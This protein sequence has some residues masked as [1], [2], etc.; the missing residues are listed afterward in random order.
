MN[1]PAAFRVALLDDDESSRESLDALLRSA[2]FDVRA[3]AVAR[4]FLDWDAKESIDLAILDYAM[5]PMNGGEVQEVLNTRGRSY[6]VIFLTA[7]AS[8]A[9]RTRLVA[10]GAVG[11]LAKPFEAEMLLAA[12]ET[13]LASPTR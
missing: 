10:A 3:F 5:S 6:P 7:L 8:E 1:V 12:I 13:A 2:G 4:D 9:L 11:V